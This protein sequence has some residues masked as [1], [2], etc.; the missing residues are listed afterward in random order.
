MDQAVTPATFVAIYE[1]HARDVYRYALA[2]GGNV[3]QAEDLAAEAFLRVWQAGSR[4]ELLS[5]RAYL[6]AIVRNLHRSSWRVERRRDAM[7]VDITAPADD[8]AVH[9][10]LE[11]VLKALAQLDAPDRDVVLLRAEGGLSYEEIAAL[12]GGTASSVRVRAYRAR[13]RLMAVL[14]PTKK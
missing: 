8:P 4:V 2:L 13:K 6:V 3:T 12:T 10:D 14:C 1:R 7:P 5:V 9:V 11:R